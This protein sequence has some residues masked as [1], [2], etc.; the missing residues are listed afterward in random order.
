MRAADRV[1][2]RML[3]MRVMCVLCRIFMELNL[4]PF[5]DVYFY[6]RDTLSLKQMAYCL[7]F[8]HDLQVEVYLF[9]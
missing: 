2:E 9:L 3:V 7:L 8:K 1:L 4:K 5:M 6:L